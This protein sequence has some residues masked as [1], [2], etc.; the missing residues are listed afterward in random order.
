[1]NQELVL[2]Q[3]RGWFLKDT[4]IDLLRIIF[5]N[6]WW[7]SCQI[8][9]MFTRFGQRSSKLSRHNGKSPQ[10][11]LKKTRGC[12]FTMHRINSGNWNC[13]TKEVYTNAIQTTLH[14]TFSP[15]QAKERPA[16]TFW[17]IIF[18]QRKQTNP[19][20]WFQT[21]PSCFLG[22]G[23]I[24]PHLTHHDSPWRFPFRFPGSNQHFRW[25]GSNQWS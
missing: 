22:W 3:E 18:W 12:D 4:S 1:M 8:V 16:K 25:S 13:H 2:A 21:S 24:H 11:I 9:S 7:L 23:L 6:L 20:R 19:K 15:R 10:F 14:E 17:K 5:S